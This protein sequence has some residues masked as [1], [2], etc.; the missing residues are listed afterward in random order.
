MCH[1]KS[2]LKQWHYETLVDIRIEMGERLVKHASGAALDKLEPLLERIRAFT[3]LRE[4]TRGVFYYKSQAFLHFHE[5]IDA[6]YADVKVDGS[7]QRY[8]VTEANDQ[9]SLLDAISKARMK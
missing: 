3:G 9:R 7:W 5:E 8:D 2:W 4:K 6:V 1:G